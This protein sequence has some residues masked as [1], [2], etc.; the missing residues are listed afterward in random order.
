[1]KPKHQYGYNSSHTV[2]CERTL[3]SLLRGIGPW[4]EGIFVIGGLAPRYLIPTTTESGTPPHIGTTDV[5]L[6]LNLALLAEI[7]AYK[8]L[9]QNLKDLNF[10]RG[11][12]EEG[13]PQHF[14]W[15]K[16]VGEG[17][18]IV[19]DLLCD[20]P[21][22]EGGKVTPI[23]GERRL[24]ALGIPGA[25]LAMEDFVE[26]S[27]TQELLDDRGVATEVIRVAN[28]VPLLV[29]KCLA[30]DDRM[31]EKDAYDIIYCLTYYGS[32]PEDVANAYAA[33]L[34]RIP[35]DPFLR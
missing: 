24:S 28:I 20:K 32:G 14:S 2:L 18:T 21:T 33:S 27:L 34:V 15:R 35:E 30:Y 22:E 5:D 23:F 4:K 10:K 3:V 7:E 8:K 11:E 26:V 19:V 16:E 17:A 29:L 6:V 12:N 31:E 9:E 13:R 1:M 25:Y